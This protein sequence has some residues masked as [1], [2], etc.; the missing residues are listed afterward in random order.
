MKRTVLAWLGSTSA[1]LAT[2]SPDSFSSVSS[3][4]SSSCMPAIHSAERPCVAA[5]I[6]PNIMIMY[7][8]AWF[9]RTVAPRAG[10]RPLVGAATRFLDIPTEILLTDLPA[11]RQ[12]NADAGAAGPLRQPGRGR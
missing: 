2:H 10:A 12:P 7:F 3:F 9:L 11:E 4:I 6:P 1:S 8:I 5:P